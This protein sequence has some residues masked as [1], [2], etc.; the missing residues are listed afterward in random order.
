MLSGL[1][2]RPEKKPILSSSWKLPRGSSDP[3]LPKRSNDVLRAEF[4]A[5]DVTKEGKL[6]FHSVRMALNMFNIV[7]T[8]EEIM[9]W[10]Q[11]ADVLNKGFVDFTD[12]EKISC[13]KVTTSSSEQSCSLTH[14]NNLLIIKRLFEQ[15]DRNRDGFISRED[16]ISA[17]NKTQTVEASAVMAWMDLMDEDKTGLVSFEAFARRYLS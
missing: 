4:D 7:S 9:S 12:F 13:M 16:L 17:L 3:V 8:D 1:P 6:T 2:P 11:Q 10:I 14:S 15:Y 5:L